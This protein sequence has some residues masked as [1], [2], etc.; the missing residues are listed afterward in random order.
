MKKKSNIDW[1]KCGLCGGDYTK[2]SG[3][4]ICSKCGHRY[5][6]KPFD[7]RKDWV[8]GRI[9]PV[10]PSDDIKMP[11]H[12]EGSAKRYDHGVKFKK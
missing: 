5:E 2:V 10:I 11:L 1:S 8:T 12:L 6:H 9:D 3:F 4:H 7:N